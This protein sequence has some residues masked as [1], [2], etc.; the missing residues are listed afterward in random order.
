M[1]RP[2]P[3]CWF[4]VLVARNDAAAALEALAGTGAV[5]LEPQALRQSLPSLAELKPALDRY[6]DLCNRFRPYW[7]T[8]EGV[9]LP[10]T[11]GAPEILDRGLECID[12]WRAEAE[13]LIHRLQALNEEGA[14]LE[15]W[16]ELLA[17]TTKSEIEFGL[18]RGPEALLAR[19]LYVLPPQARLSLPAP[20]LARRFELA[21]KTCLLAVAPQDAAIELDRRIAA[22]RGRRLGL[23]PVWL[24]GPAKESLSHLELRRTDR[25]RERGS[26]SRD[27]GIESP[28]RACGG[29]RRHR[30]PEVVCFADA[31]TCCHGL[32][33]VA[34]GVELG[35][36][37]RRSDRCARAC[38]R[39]RVAAF[40]ATPEGR[41]AAATPAQSMVGAAV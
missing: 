10:P 34:Y 3:A 21:G 37:R 17:C 36:D 19:R 5:E 1:L 24:R 6:Q 25:G 27:R 31:R 30:A 22:L 15:I 39:A 41:R 18:L 29:D 12:A 33:R 16:R 13:P 20:A 9:V 8:A 28:P 38:E 23:D 4:E 40:F 14:E 26:A 35:F 2:V 32:L 11:Q 7:P